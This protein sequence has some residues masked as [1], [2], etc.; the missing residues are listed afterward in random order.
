MMDQTYFSGT[1][2]FIYLYDVY[3]MAL[4]HNSDHIASNEWMVSE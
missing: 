4:F 2:Y 1:L 3:L